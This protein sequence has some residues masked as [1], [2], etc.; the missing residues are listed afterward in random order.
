MIPV[1]NVDGYRAIGNAYTATGELSY[2]RKN[3]HAY[4]EQSLCAETQKGVDLKRNYGYK[5]N[6]DDVGSSSDVCADNYRGP[7]AFSE[8]ETQVI[9][10]FIAGWPNLKVAINLYT[11]GNIL[12]HPFNFDSDSTDLLNNEFPQAAQWYQD[13]I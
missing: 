4:D 1:V 3:M 6:Y 7:S 2:Y 8:P 12:V 9:R 10:D 13:L 5:F 11:Y